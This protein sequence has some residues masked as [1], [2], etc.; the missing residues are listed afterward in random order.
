[1]VASWH[2]CIDDC[3]LNAVT[4]CNAYPLPRIDSTPDSLAGAT[5]F[6]TLD[7]ASGYWQMAVEENDKVKTAFSTAEGSL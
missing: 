2:F 3:K 1:M 4:C 6:T 5:F 7:L